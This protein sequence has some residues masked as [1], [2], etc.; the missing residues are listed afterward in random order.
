MGP[1]LPT[2]R[3]TIG[4]VDWIRITNEANATGEVV[5]YAYENQ[6]GV[7][8]AAGDVGTPMRARRL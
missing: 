5:G 4:T 8:I 7:A 1:I 2:T 3:S 6:L